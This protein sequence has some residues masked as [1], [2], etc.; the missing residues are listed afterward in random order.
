MLKMS[1]KIRRIILFSSAKP[2]SGL[3]LA[4]LLLAGSSVEANEVTFMVYNIQSPDWSLERRENIN[5]IILGY[6]PD[7]IGLNEFSTNSSAEA[8]EDLEAGGYTAYTGSTESTIYIGDA[9]NLTYFG[10]NY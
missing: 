1:G 5:E 4:L 8:G 6:L 3:F 7:V 10:T 9:T 2:V